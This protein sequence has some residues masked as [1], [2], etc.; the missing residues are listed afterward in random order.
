[1]QKQKSYQEWCVDTLYQMMLNGGT[2][3]GFLCDHAYKSVIKDM[4][5]HY[6]SIYYFKDDKIHGENS[7]VNLW[8]GHISRDTIAPLLVSCNAHQFFCNNLGKGQIE[9]EKKLQKVFHIEHITPMEYVYT[10]LKNVF[11][12]GNIT[13]DMV[14]ACFAQ[15]KLIFITKEEARKLDGAGARFI[16]DDYNIFQRYFQGMFSADFQEEIKKICDG[17]MR[18]K[19]EGP[20]LLRMIRLYNEGV[21]FVNGSDG[22]EVAIGKGWV[23]YLTDYTNTIIQ[24]APRTTPEAINNRKQQY[25]ILWSEFCGWCREKNKKWITANPD[26][27]Y[28]KNF[29]DPSGRG[30]PHLF[31][32]V[33][34]D[35]DDNKLYLGIYSNMRQLIKEKCQAELDQLGKVNWEFGHAG[36]GMTSILIP[37]NGDWK[38]LSEG[39]FA[40]MADLFESV[41]TTLRKCGFKI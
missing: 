29:L 28:C 11:L 24:A 1:M 27:N 18:P 10:R 17:H 9:S 3:Q 31:F 26:S 6:A 15:N 39:L 16:R 41:L 25:Q 20:G 8:W 30:N 14:S 40:T 34:N 22:V 12:R 13:R 36:Q 23:D 21:R 32:R 2:Y 7:C 38:N 19:S 33:S 35:N 4:I 5:R 37:V